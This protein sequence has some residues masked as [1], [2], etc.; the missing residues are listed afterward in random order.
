MPS[1]I[2]SVEQSPQIEISGILTAVIFHQKPLETDSLP[3]IEPWGRRNTDMQRK[4]K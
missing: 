3:K 1:I 2:N 4:S